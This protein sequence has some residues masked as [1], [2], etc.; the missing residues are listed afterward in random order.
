MQKWFF[1]CF[2]TMAW[3]SLKESVNLT[4]LT[5]T[6]IS[7]LSNLRVLSWIECNILI[8]ECNETSSRKPFSGESRGDVSPL[9]LALV[10][11]FTKLEL[12]LPGRE[13]A[14]NPPRNR[15]ESIP[16]WT[17][18]PLRPWACCISRFVKAT[19]AVHQSNLCAST[20]QQFQPTCYMGWKTDYNM[21]RLYLLPHRTRCCYKTDSC[22]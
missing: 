13:E 22:H 2:L 3:S 8:T 10:F 16:R 14:K 18:C 5:S 7:L 21:H 12:V 15:L 20:R 9:W 11:R 17:W 1:S 19:G 4:C 6:V